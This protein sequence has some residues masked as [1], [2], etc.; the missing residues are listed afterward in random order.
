MHKKRSYW[1]LRSLDFFQNTNGLQTLLTGLGT[2]RIVKN[3]HL[4]IEN[5]A[6]GLRHRAAFSKHLLQFF[7]IWTSQVIC[8]SV[9]QFN[10]FKNP[11]A[12]AK[13]NN[14]LICSPLTNHCLLLDRTPSNNCSLLP[15]GSKRVLIYIRLLNELQIIILIYSYI[16]LNSIFFRIL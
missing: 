14:K 3:C 1:L 2:V 16:F 8:L 10:H 7:P 4:G 6:L 5:A 9:T 13:K 15:K 11:S 12:S